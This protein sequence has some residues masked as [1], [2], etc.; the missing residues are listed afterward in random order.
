MGAVASQITSFTIVYST[1]YARADKKKSKRL[2]TGLCE[3]N[4]PVTGEFPAPMVSN[5]EKGIHL[6]T[7]SGSDMIIPIMPD[8]VLYTWQSITV[9]P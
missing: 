3:G 8:G 2:A 6:M 9:T 5:A 4:S 7:S 1:V